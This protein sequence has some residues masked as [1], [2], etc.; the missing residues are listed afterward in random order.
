MH[1]DSTLHSLPWVLTEGV[2]W[3]AKQAACVRPLQVAS[4]Q[5]YGTSAEVYSFSIILWQLVSH[6]VPYS[7]MNAATFHRRVVVDGL[8]PPLSKAWPAPLS[9]LLAECWSCNPTERPAMEDV[10]PSARPPHHTSLAPPRPASQVPLSL[11]HHAPPCVTRT[12]ASH[13]IGG[14][15]IAR[16]SR[17]TQAIKGMGSYKLHAGGPAVRLRGRV[18]VGDGSQLAYRAGLYR[19]QT[20]MA[21]I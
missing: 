3:P 21:K 2:P 16:Y 10:T 19:R 9:R 1:P 4:S 12:L 8:R 11:T 7:G 5:P 18:A 15:T 14:P 20:Q 6:E 13:C 17:C